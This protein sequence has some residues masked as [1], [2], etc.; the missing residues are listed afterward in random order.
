MSKPTSLTYN[1]T[2]WAAYNAA[3]KRRGSLTIL[4]DPEMN[5]DAKPSGKRGRSR[6]F[7]DAAIQTC[8]TMKV[9]FGMALRQTTG[10]V[11][12]LLRLTGLDWDVPDFSTICR[13]QRTL[14]VNIPYRGAKGPLHLLID[15][16]G[17]KVE[18]E[19]EWNARK[20]GGPKRRVWR[21]IH[22]GNDEQTLEVRAVEITGSNTGDTPM[23]PYLL[24]QIPRDQQIGSVTADSAYDTR[25]CH[26]AIAERGAA[27]VIPPRPR[28][29]AMEANHCRRHRQERRTPRIKMSGPGT[30]AKLERIPPPEPRQ[31]ETKM[32]CM[33][34]L[35]QR[36]MA[37]DFDR[38]VAEVQVRVAILNGYTALGI[39]V[40]KA[41]G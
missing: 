22:I 6:T 21:K 9:L 15:R 29:P 40:T 18:G 25:Q 28:R 1:T 20:H 10:F 32:H 5:W 30:L 4:F 14:A 31:D 39:P 26:N 35:G 17:I 13:R 11:E 37:R 27:A 41:V 19:G 8:L 33:K 38:Q 23:L 3:L 7:S 12:S 16:T 2:N 34:L 36:L 24:N